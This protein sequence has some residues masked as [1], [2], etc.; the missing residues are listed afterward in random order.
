MQ[1]TVVRIDGYGPWTLT[2]GSDREH[3]LQALQASLYGS[4]QRAFSSRGCLLF[5]GRSDELFAASSGLDAAGHEAVLAEA[6]GPDGPDI[7]MSVGRA[8]TPLGADEAA[9]DA[10]AAGGRG[11]VRGAPAAS[12]EDRVTVLHLDVDGLTSAR[13]GM[14]AY[15]VSSAIFGLYSRMS[16]FFLR[17]GSLAFF[18]GGDNF[19]VL[20][21][22]GGKEAAA[23]FLAEARAAGMPMNCGVGTGPTGREAAR[24]ATRSLDEIRRMRDSGGDRPEVYEMPCS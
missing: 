16:E 23:G 17:R 15:E 11:P 1:L 21:G 12:P 7:S 22:D 14:T 2:L 5:P 9:R 19:M 24:L 13:R 18:M 10:A 8:E 6:R 3:E 4:L 20:A